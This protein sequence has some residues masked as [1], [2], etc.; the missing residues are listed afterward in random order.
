M[1]TCPKTVTHPGKL[2]NGA[3]RIGNY[4]DRTQR[5]NHYRLEMTMGM[6]FPMGM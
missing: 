2:T 1:V 5:L 3:W 6:G 4:V